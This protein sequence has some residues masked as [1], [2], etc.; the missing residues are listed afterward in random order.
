MA[1][2]ED[3]AW[4]IE[5]KDSSGAFQKDLAEFKKMLPLDDKKEMEKGDVIWLRKEESDKG[6]AYLALEMPARFVL[7]LEA[8]ARG[9]KKPNFRFERSKADLT[10][11]ALLGEFEL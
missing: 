4:K 9:E 8:I 10:K 3:S 5:I 6:K 11:R 2:K 7:L 1:K